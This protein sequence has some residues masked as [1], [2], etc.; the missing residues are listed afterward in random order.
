MVGVV[1]DGV[2]DGLVPCEDVVVDEC[3][4]GRRWCPTAAAP[5]QDGQ[6]VDDDRDQNHHR[7][8]PQSQNPPLEVPR[9]GLSSAPKRSV[10]SMFALPLE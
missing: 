2:G 4:R 9:R 5:G 6:A 3:V 8:A 7:Q 10:S 1:D